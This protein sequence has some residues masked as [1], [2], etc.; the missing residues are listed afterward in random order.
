MDRMTAWTSR[1][2]LPAIP[3]L[4]PAV[5]VTLFCSRMAV[6]APLPRISTGLR[7][8]RRWILLEAPVVPIEAQH[9]KISM[10]AETARAEF[11]VCHA[12]PGEDV[13]VVHRV[14]V[15]V[16]RTESG[17]SVSASPGPLLSRKRA[18]SRLTF[19]APITATASAGVVNGIPRYGCPLCQDTR[20]AAA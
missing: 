18:R 3:T 1:F 2:S 13:H 19:P 20:S 6:T 17:T 15:R 10:R 14:A 4:S 12:A 11:D 9:R 7:R 5:P 8:K 16:S